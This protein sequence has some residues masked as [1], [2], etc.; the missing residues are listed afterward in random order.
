METE[1][2]KALSSLLDE[3]LDLPPAEREAWLVARS[4]GDDALLVPTLRELLQQHSN[5]GASDWL[6]QGPALSDLA[7]VQGPRAGM[8]PTEGATVGPYRLSRLL[9]RGGMGDVWLAERSD[10]NLKRLIALKLPMISLRREMLVQRF[11]RERDIGAVLAHPHIARLYDAGIADDGQPYLALE[12]VDG[13]PIDRWCEVRRLAAAA[14]IELF[15]QVLEAVQHAHAHLVV[16]RDLKPSNVLVTHDGRAMLLDFGIAKLIEPDH[17]SVSATELTQ[18]GGRAMTLQYA[19]PE[20]LTGGAISI[21]TDI[22]ACGVLLHELLCGQRPFSHGARS[23]METAILQE[24]PP[25]LAGGSVT[26]LPR[27]RLS[28]LHTIVAKALHKAPARRYETASALADDLRRWLRQEPVLAQPSSRWYRL[29]TFTA[30]HRVGVAI[31]SGMFAIVLAAAAISTRQAQIAQ[32]QA[33]IASEEARTAEAVQSFIE[34]IFRVNSIDQADPVKARSRTAKQLLDEG[35]ARIDDA[36]SDA[37]AAKLRLLS[38]LAE[39]YEN[40]TEVQAAVTMYRRRAELAAQV[41]GTA[42]P[43]TALAL[44]ELGRSLANAEDLRASREALER[45]EAIL[46]AH[47]DPSGRAEIARD[48]GLAT[49]YYRTDPA[50]G[51]VPARRLVEALRGGAVS[52]QR[53]GAYVLLGLTLHHDGQVDAARTV[54]EEGMQ[55]ANAAPGVGT[56][57]RMEMHIALARVAGEQGDVA[58]A[59]EHYEH[60]LR[61]STV[62]NGATGL[63][64]LVT[65]GQL[66]NTLSVNGLPQ[67]GAEWLER[68]LEEGLAWPD[69][70]DRTAYLPGFA[71][72]AAEGALRAGRPRQALERADLTLRYFD[73]AKSN[74]RWFVT[75]HSVRALALLQ[76]GRL[77][78]AGSALAAGQSIANSPSLARPGLA[79]ALAL[80]R[81]RLLAQQKDGAGAL[82]HWQAYVAATARPGQ[83]PGMR[84]LVHLAEFELAARRPDDAL[85]HADEVLARLASHPRR[86]NDA[87]IEA[88]AHRWR[89]QALFELG[90]YGEATRSLEEAVRRGSVLY[91]PAASPWL[92]EARSAHAEA[93]RRQSRQ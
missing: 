75:A 42:S 82:A 67:E 50:K 18:L 29:R 19:A 10:G 83:P 70:Q 89:G 73:P 31:G 15:L 78:E 56:T 20:Q 17:G 43:H 8:A 33:R 6:E 55:T 28:E 62:T 26:S 37:P 68:S 3:M 2:L 27:R 90:R 92:S 69:S 7:T 81:A 39:L 13:E 88:Q 23:R 21:A 12:Y 54:L 5:S 1:S 4:G 84:S 16:H 87:E 46:Q 47:P 52:A 93:L 53:L 35:A 38:T 9:G 72:Y 61:L 59:R 34:G 24:D 77:Q 60:A 66:G 44:A 64:A 14:R 91:D 32:E 49:L 41:Y 86:E 85:A 74:P 80:G 36:M 30:R 25:R 79:Q 51:V 58:T 40:M 45:A 48:L 11:A 65:M 63:H 71:A 76:M 22:W 57:S